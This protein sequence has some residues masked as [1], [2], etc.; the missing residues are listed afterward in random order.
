MH[1]SEGEKT[2]LRA[3]RPNIRELDRVIQNHL[4]QSAPENEKALQDIQIL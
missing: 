4:S 3:L 2:K 1:R